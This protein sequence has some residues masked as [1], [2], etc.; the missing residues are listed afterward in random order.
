MSADYSG[1]GPVMEKSGDHCAEAI[2]SVQA[3]LQGLADAPRALPEILRRI[4]EAH[5]SLLGLLWTIDQRAGALRLAESWYSPAAP[6]AAR[7][8]ETNKSL[9][10]AQG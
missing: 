10:F 4:A 2:G 8:V 1:T 3:I 5:G 9:T 7:F 6:T